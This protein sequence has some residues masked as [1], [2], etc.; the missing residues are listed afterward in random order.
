MQAPSFAT[1]GRQRRS[2]WKSR[3]QLEEEEMAAMPTFH[4]RP[5]KFVPVNWLF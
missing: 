3:E 2:Q 4:A 5:V 1:D